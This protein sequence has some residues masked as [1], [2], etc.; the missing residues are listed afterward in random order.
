M[1]SRLWILFVCLA[2]GCSR[3]GAKSAGA[4]EELLQT[5]PPGAIVTAPIAAVGQHLAALANRVATLPGGEQLGDFR[6]GVAAQ[7]G[8]DPLTREGQLAAGL[9]PDRGAAVAVYQGQPRPDWIAALPLTKPDL[10]L[11]TVQRILVERAG[12]APVAEQPKEAKI[13]ERRG[14]R[15]GVAVV[16]GYGL[17][18]RTADPAGA[19]AQAAQRKPEQSLARDPAFAAA[20]DRLGGQD[21]IAYAPRGSALAAR[22]GTRPPGDAAVA[23]QGSQQGVAS[24]FYLQLGPDDAQRAQVALS[25]GG[26]S[27]V[28]LLPADAPLRARLGVAPARLLEMLRNDAT[29]RPILDQLRGADAEVFAALEPGAALSLSIARG[30]SIAAAIDY[31][32][33]WRRKS[34]FDTVQL[35]ALANVADRGRLLRALDQVAKAL[36][37]LGAKVERSGDDFQIT[38]SGGRGARFGVR[39]IDGKPVAYLMGGPLRPDELRRT[40]RSANPEA[41]ALYEGNGAAARIDFGKLAASVHDLPESTYGTGPQSY[42]TRS[43]VAQVIDPL[44]TVRLSVAA[45]AFPD[46]LGGSLDVELVSP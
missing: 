42:V 13:F 18:A 28:E 12:F 38:Y 7:L 5:A 25:G 33:D 45:E 36:P 24:R 30:A 40:P 23:M 43:L 11:Q 21:F 19:I 20:R 6:R 44:R 29:L 17:I 9:D 41:A 34:P 3:C 10:F 27:L 4:A 8:F 16:R 31:G 39:E 26:A 14:Q 22:H 15:L 32:L 2:A 1:R 35:V 37:S 46:R